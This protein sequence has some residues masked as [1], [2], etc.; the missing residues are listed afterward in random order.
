VVAGAG[1][2]V[3]KHEITGLLPL[4]AHPMYWKNLGYQFKNNSEQLNEDLERANICFLHA[5]YFHPALQSVGLLRKS[6]GLRTF[7]IFW[8]FGKSCKT[9]IFNDRSVQP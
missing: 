4:Q 6:L 5:P 7:L 8:A 1:Q 9:S 3:T 2:K